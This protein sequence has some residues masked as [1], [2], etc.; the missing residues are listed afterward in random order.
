LEIPRYPKPSFLFI[1]EPLRYRLASG[2]PVRKAPEARQSRA[3]W[4]PMAT[5]QLFRTRKVPNYLSG[6]ATSKESIYA[7]Q[8]H[9]LRPFDP[10]TRHVGVWLCQ[11]MGGHGWNLLFRSE[12]PKSLYWQKT[13]YHSSRRNYGRPHLKI[14][15][16]PVQFAQPRTISVGGAPPVR[17]VQ[18][19]AARKGQGYP[20]LQLSHCR[21]FDRIA[22]NRSRPST[23]LTHPLHCAH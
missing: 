1:I 12:H 3:E 16:G 22:R 19:A 15:A 2:L 13:R 14:L 5:P 23:L 4:T 10:G 20:L 17:A 21:I 8:H 6:I 18:P 11:R 9:H 7:P